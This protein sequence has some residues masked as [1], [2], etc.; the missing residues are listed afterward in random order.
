[1]SQLQC[2]YK[3]IFLYLNKYLYF[4][5]KSI[6]IVFFFNFKNTYIH[7]NTSRRIQC[8]PDINPLI[9]AIHIYEYNKNFKFRLT[10]CQKIGRLW[11]LK[12][13]NSQY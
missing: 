12:E 13:L 6:S 3:Y 8:N 4:N 7:T 5:M 9:I 10:Q 11:R 1:M 2:R